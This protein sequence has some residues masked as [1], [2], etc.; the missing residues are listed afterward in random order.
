[1]IYMMSDKDIA[2]VKEHQVFKYFREEL[3][4]PEDFAVELAYD[5]IITS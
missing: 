5:V 2:L 4:F 3:E 1:M